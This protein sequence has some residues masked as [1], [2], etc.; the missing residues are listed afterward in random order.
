MEYSVYLQL[1][2]LGSIIPEN[3]DK[4]WHIWNIDTMSNF[5]WLFPKGFQ[6]RFSRRY[7]ACSNQ[8]IRSTFRKTGSPFSGN[9]ISLFWKLSSPVRK[10]G[11][12]FRKLGAPF[13]KLGPPF[14]KHGSPF[15][16]QG[17]FLQYQSSHFFLKKAGP[18]TGNRVSHTGNRVP[19]WQ[20]GS[21]FPLMTLFWISDGLRPKMKIRPTW[22]FNKLSWYLLWKKNR[23]FNSTFPLIW[24]IC[25]WLSG[26]P[27]YCNKIGEGT[28]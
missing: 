2:L 28:K 10:L 12:P 7:I 4:V 1:W 3:L 8:K 11:P 21:P 13:E 25:T 19:I 26:P 27:K 20:T 22:S 18:H 9:R 23:E 16:N 5:Y 15:R 17:N 6:K 24:I 14:G